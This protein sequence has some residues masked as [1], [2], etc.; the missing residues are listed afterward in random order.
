M[1]RL[2]P[3]GAAAALACGT[4]LAVPSAA[5]ACPAGTDART[6]RVAG[7]AQT[8]CVPGVQCSPLGCDPWLTR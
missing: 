5:I 7:H 6:V 1:R 3:A 2:L 4:L 8:V